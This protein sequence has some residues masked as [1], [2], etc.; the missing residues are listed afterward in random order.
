VW[1]VGLRDGERVGEHSVLRTSTNECLHVGRVSVGF[2]G[3]DKPSSDA[4]CSSTGSKC[5][6]HRARRANA[7]GGYDGDPYGFKY[8]PKQREKPKVAAHMPSGLDALGRDQIASGPLGGDRLV[9]RASV[10]AGQRSGRVDQ[11]DESRIR[12]AKKD[13]TT[14]ARGATVFNVSLLRNGITKFT[15]IGAPV[16]LAAFSSASTR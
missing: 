10:P 15:P 11:F 7:T 3:G 12:I 5:S 16:R 14:L 4:D 2:L 1:C 9:D 8:L 13:S 6:C